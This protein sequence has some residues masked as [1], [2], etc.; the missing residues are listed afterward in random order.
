VLAYNDSRPQPQAGLQP[1]PASLSGDDHA[2]ALGI[3]ANGVITLCRA[4]IAAGHNPAAPLDAYRSD[5]LCLHVRSIGEATAL[6]VG[7]VGFVRDRAFRVARCDSKRHSG[8]LKRG[9][10]EARRKAAAS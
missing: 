2:E 8:R 3:E 10:A 5:V 6:R 4:M 7:R 1:I 9:R